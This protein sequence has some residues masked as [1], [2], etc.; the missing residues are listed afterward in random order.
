MSRIT[1]PG[2]EKGID[3]MNMWWWDRFDALGETMRRNDFEGWRLVLSSVD[4][5]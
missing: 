4:N 3:L 5:L 2:L 1:P